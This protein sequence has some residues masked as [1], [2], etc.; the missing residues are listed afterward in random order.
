MIT[1]HDIEQGTPEWHEL[2]DAAVALAGCNGSDEDVLTYAM[3][4]KVAP[5]FFTMRAQ[6]PNNLGKAPGA[7]PAAAAPATAPPV[8]NGKAPLRS[9]V[10][11]DVKCNGKT[12]RVTVSPA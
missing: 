6:G 8:E 1:V 5:K 3:F 11:Y 12:H 4:P 7:Q 2:R 9:P 10:T